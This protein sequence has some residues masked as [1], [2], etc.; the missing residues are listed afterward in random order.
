M[1]DQYSFAQGPAKPATL[2]DLE[3]DREGITKPN[4]HRRIDPD[5]KEE[6]EG[7]PVISTEYSITVG[8][9]DSFRTT[10]QTVHDE[11]STTSEVP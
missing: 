7:S 3:H 2:E 6:P 11:D 5:I 4:L 9:V 1:A 10:D 8:G